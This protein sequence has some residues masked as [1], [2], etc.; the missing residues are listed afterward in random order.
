MF[1][2]TSQ[3][4]QE[5]LSEEAITNFVTE[6]CTRCAFFLDVLH[7]CGDHKIKKVIVGCLENWC[8]AGNLFTRVPAPMPIVKQW[9]KV[10]FV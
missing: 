9:I 4:S 3:E 7:Q 1:E 8:M 2:H 5:D 10:T 6:S